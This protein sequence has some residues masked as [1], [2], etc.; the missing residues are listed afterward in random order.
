MEL[1]QEWKHLSCELEKKYLD[2]QETD[3]QLTEANEKMEG[4]QDI[5]SRNK[6]D[7]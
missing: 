3:K 6:R 1:E 5:E 4:L 7:A 2:K